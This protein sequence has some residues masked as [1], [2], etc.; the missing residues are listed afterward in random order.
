MNRTEGLP[1]NVM[2]EMGGHHFVALCVLKEGYKFFANLLD[3]IKA[4]TRNSDRSIP[5]T[6]EF[7]RLKSYCKDQSTGGIKVN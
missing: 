1:Q 5:M 2:R 4:L 6:V 3:Y 7:I